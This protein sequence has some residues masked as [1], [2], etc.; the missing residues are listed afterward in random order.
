MKAYLTQMVMI[1][2]TLPT[3]LP[4]SRIPYPR[5]GNVLWAQ[6]RLLGRAHVV[7]PAHRSCAARQPLSSVASRRSTVPLDSQLKW[8]R[9]LVVSPMLSLGY[10]PTLV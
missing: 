3:F 7:V 1:R 9:P 4:V 5:E 2:T 10:S 6:L 8:F